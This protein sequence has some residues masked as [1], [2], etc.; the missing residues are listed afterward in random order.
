MEGTDTGVNDSGQPHPAGAA[1]I[2]S[3][4]ARNARNTTLYNMRMR[5]L[6]NDLMCEE[7]HKAAGPS[8]Q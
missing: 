3:R 8:A 6:P 2:E 1:G 4:R 5:C 7:R